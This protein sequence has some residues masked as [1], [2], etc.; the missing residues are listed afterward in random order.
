MANMTNPE[1][2][3]A[4]REA[5]L[6]SARTVFCRK[7]LIGVTMKDIIEECGIS[8]GG[9]YLYF[10]SVDAIFVETVKQRTNRKSDSI[11]QAIKDNMPFDELLNAYFV[12]HKDRLLNYMGNSMLRSM[13]E[14]FFTHKAEEDQKFQQEQLA[15]V[16]LTICEILQLGV[17]QGVLRNH[18]MDEIAENFMFVIEGLSVLALIGGITEEHIDR[19]INIMCSL[20]PRENRRQYE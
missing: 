14:Y 10:D 12:G 3:K 9:I 5:I 7:G 19:Q 11:R 4:K 8:R 6:D 1:R 18:A 15:H 16:K 13:Y 2:R 20:L 17:R